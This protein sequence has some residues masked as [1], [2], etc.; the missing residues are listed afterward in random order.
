MQRR[1]VRPTI[2]VQ[3]TKQDPDG[4]E[5]F[6]RACERL[7]A[8]PVTVARAMCDALAEIVLGKDETEFEAVTKAVAKKTAKSKK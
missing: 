1:R 3:W 4:K 6:E 8:A 2:L 5:R 7:G